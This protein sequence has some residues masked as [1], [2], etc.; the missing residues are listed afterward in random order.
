MSS[1]RAADRGFT[2][3]E[4]LVALSVF[5]LAVLA[6]LN[7]SGENARTAAVLQ[8]QML[9]GMVAD[10]RAVES[11]LVPLEALEAAGD[12]VEEAGGVGW[13]WQRSLSDTPDPDIVRVD[14]QVAG[15]D[16]PQVLASLVVFR[17]RR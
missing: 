13:R 16:G 11:M 4:T 6:L 5:S 15:P 10:N 1:R 9:A 3:I 14:I 17:S 8:E 2:L 7:L 12:G